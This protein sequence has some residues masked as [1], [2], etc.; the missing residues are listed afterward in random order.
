MKHLA[1]IIFVFS[2]MSVVVNA[3]EQSKKSKRAQSKYSGLYEEGTLNGAALPV[4]MPYNRWIDPAGKQIY[5]GDATKENHALDCSLSPDGKWVA[6]EGRYSVVI[7]STETQKQVHRFSLKSYF[8]KENA[9]NTFSGI[10]WQKTGKKY[11][12]F[13]STASKSGKSFVVQANWNNRKITIS[14][15]F[16]FA[17]EAQAA[18]A[19]PNELFVVDEGGATSLLVVLNGNNKLVK[20]DVATGKIIWS[21]ATGVAPYGITMA[22]GK[23][24]VTNWAGSVPAS[25]DKNVAGV[26]WGLAKVDP[27]TGATREGTVSVFDPATGRLLKEIIVGLHPN[28]IISASD[29]NFVYVANANS[30]NISV[31][32]TENDVVT[33]TIRVRSGEEK[34]PFFGSSPNGLGISGDGTTLYVANGMDNAVGVV[35]LGNKSAKNSSAVQSQIAGFIPTGAYPGAVCNVQNK[36]LFVP[37]IEAEGARIPSVDDA[38]G[39]ISYNSHRMMASVSVIPLPDKKQLKEYTRRVEKSNQLFRIDLAQKMP[40]KNAKPVPVPARIGE[41]SVFKH[42]VYIIKENRTYDQILGDMKSGDGDASLCVF[43]KQVTPN[44]H[45]ICNDFFLMDNFYASGKCSAEGHQWTDMA[46]VND[47]I[48]KNVRAWFR[49]YP[50]VQ[51]D[52]LAYTPTGFIWDNALRHGKNVRIYGEACIPVFDKSYTWTSIYE[53]FKKGEKFQFKNKTTIDPVKGILSPNYP[54]YDS[55]KVPD[56]LRAKTFIDELKEYEK[57]PGDQWPELIVIA[58]PNDHTGGTRVG[59]PTPRAMVADNDLALG[60]IVEAITKSRFWPGTAVFVTEDD[61]QAG[62]DHVSAYRTVGA[63][64]SPYSR[65]KK[66][67]RTNYNQVSIFRTIEQILGLPPL[68]IQDATAMPMFDCFSSEPDLAA[69][70]SVPNEIPLNEMNKNLSQLKGT[71]LHFAKKSADPQFDRIDSGEDE[72]FNRIIWFATKGKQAYPHR[73]S[74]SDDDD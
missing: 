69:F 38:T 56:I 20:L 11:S 46:M 45:K 19:L 18:S 60:Q 43:G 67:V 41:P 22:G 32:E 34:N 39:N 15:I 59:L 71:A 28:D 70:H 21:V 73:F 40:R 54:G 47:Y 66:T 2:L 27:E 53:G 25:G 4:M 24:Y 3:Q 14:K 48:E 13:W 30:D 16:P 55:H 51:D 68:N 72:L 44:I 23:I 1:L 37:N 50:H 6:V 52:A 57:Q 63:V 58:L 7:I 29:G 42:V 62:W 74:G 10:L 49:S 26:P 12:L 33:E 64:I 61:S 36:Y 9:M 5:F 17:A 8:E 65:L 35:N 31:I